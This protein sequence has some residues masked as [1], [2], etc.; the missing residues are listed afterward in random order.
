[1]KIDIDPIIQPAN[2]LEKAVIEMR[3]IEALYVVKLANGKEY[4]VQWDKKGLAEF[5]TSRTVSEM[6]QIWEDGI[7]NRYEVA[8]GALATGLHPL[9]TV[10]RQLFYPGT[11]IPMADKFET[12][13]KQ[14]DWYEKR[15][16]K[17]EMKDREQEFGKL[18]F[19]KIV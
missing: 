1:M 8:K 19:H 11:E 7:R 13:P 16:F 2:E 18:T 6:L 5:Q 17:L 3:E 10:K 12:V 4:T 15:Y 9:H 14:L